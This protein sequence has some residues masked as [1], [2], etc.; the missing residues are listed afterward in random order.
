MILYLHKIGALLFR[1]KIPILP[2]IIEGIIFIIFNSR[3]PSNVKIGKG[4]YFAYQGLSTLLVSKTTIGKNCFIGMRIT[5]GRNHPYKDVPE[6]KNNVFIGANSV[7]IGPII[8]EDNVIISPN[9][10]VNKSVPEGAIVGGIPAK[11][12]GWTSQLDYNIL[13]NP[14]YK[15]GKMPYLKENNNK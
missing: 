3:I 8:I 2:K 13:D 12:I 9:S 7:L 6:I 4:S 15:E 14:K 11:I 10:L 1:N 5:T